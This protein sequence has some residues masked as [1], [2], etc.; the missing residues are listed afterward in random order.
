MT[1][2]RTFAFVVIDVAIAV[3][4]ALVLLLLLL[5][6]AADVGGACRYLRLGGGIGGARAA[7]LRG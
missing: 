3:L 5:L 6:S 7:A 4:V 2:S 1:A